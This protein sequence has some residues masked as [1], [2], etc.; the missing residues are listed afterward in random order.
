[1]QDFV[2]QP[3]PPRLIANMLGISD[4]AP[5]EAKVETPKGA[6]QGMAPCCEEGLFY[7]SFKHGVLCIYI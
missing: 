2:H 4:L 7:M 6:F 5:Q 1:M 3:Y